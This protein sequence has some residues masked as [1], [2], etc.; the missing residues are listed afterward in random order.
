MELKQAMWIY[1]LALIIGLG[2]GTLG[3]AFHYCVEQAIQVYGVITSFFGG[4]TLLTIIVAALVGGIM[5]CWYGSMLRKL[6]GAVSRKS[7]G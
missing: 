7:K 6:R 3:A 4:S 1:L 2:V 5:V